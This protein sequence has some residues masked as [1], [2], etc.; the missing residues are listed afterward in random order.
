MQNHVLEIMLIVSLVY[1]YHKRNQRHLQIIADLKNGIVRPDPIITKELFGIILISFV[2]VLYLGFLT[3]LAF[4]FPMKIHPL[5]LIAP[6]GIGCSLIVL[7]R[8]DILL[9]Q[10]QRKE[11]KK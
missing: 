11:Q 9:Y 3:Y 8:R 1:E 7:G 5:L 6:V 10:Q 2:T 4:F